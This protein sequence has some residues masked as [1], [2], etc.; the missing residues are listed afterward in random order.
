MEREKRPLEDKIHDM[1]QELEKLK[2]EKT[3]IKNNLEQEKA[4]LEDELEKLR[5]STREK[6]MKAREDLQKQNDAVTRQTLVSKI[7]S[8]TVCIKKIKNNMQSYCSNMSLP[9]R[10]RNC[11]YFL[12]KKNNRIY[13][14]FSSM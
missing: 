10:G 12:L 11:G 7:D 5:D 3:S 4:D 8:L 13:A 14:V 6:L 9:N 2:R 1:K